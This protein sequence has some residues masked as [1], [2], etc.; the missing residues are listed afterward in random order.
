MRRHRAQLNIKPCLATRFPSLSKGLDIDLDVNMFTEDVHLAIMPIGGRTYKQK[1]FAVEFQGKEPDCERA[2]G[3][4]G[5]LGEFDRYDPTGMACDAVENIARYLA[6]EGQAVFEII[7]HKDKIYVN[8]F[9]P[10]NLFK[11]FNWYLQIIPPGDWDLWKRKFSFVNKGKVWKVE[12]PHELGGVRGYK[13]ILKKL[14]RYNR[15]GPGFYRRDLERG[16]LQGDFDLLK[17]VRDSEIYCNRVTRSWGWNRR[18][19]GQEKC[20]E[21]YSFYKMLSFKYAQALLREHILE[22]INRLLDRLE[23]KCKLIVTGLPTSGDISQIINDMR[24][25]ELSFS[26]V[27]DKVA[28]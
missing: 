10:K 3:I 28:I 21:F 23:I 20:T 8:G 22:E 24:E 7:E 9:T 26:A 2:K 19:W 5:E 4:V 6:W 25:G 12:V 17:Y 18:D 11:L 1:D 13:K 27:S 14:R 15:L 16:I